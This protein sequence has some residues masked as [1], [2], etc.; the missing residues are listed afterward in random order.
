MKLIRSLMLTALVASL[1]LAQTTQPST[2]PADEAG[3]KQALLK[4]NAAVEAV[5][6]EKI[7]SCIEFADETQK[8][9]MQLMGDLSVVSDQL[10]KATLAKFGEAEL[11]KEQVTRE[12]FQNGFPVIPLDQ[13]QIKVSGDKAALVTADGDVLPLSLTKTASGDWKI[14]GAK[15]QAFTPEQ[16]NE[17]K[18]IIDAV[19][20][21]MK[22]TTEDVKGG[23][24]RSPD[25]VPLLMQHRVT[26]AIR[27]VQMAQI[28][29]EL[30]DP[31]EGPTTGPVGPS[32]PE[33]APDAAPQK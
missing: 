32:L 16:Y 5:E 24:V 10:Y 33:K 28:P 30:L 4:F 27:Q 11:Q 20:E 15:L 8:K 26:K 25:E 19:A 21:A 6:V 22:Q 31:G 3:A 9:A 7:L 29:P 17:Q 18:K 12:R 1:T 13:I 2:Q 23:K 14:D